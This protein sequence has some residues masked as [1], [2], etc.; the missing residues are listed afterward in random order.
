MAVLVERR[1]APTVGRA[2]CSSSVVLGSDV[3]TGPKKDGQHQ[4]RFGYP[5]EDVEVTL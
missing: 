5:I 1:V 3:S 2:G 4:C